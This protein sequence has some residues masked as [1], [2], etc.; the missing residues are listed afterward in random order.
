[1]LIPSSACHKTCTNEQ[2][3]SEEETEVRRAMDESLN[4]LKAI[5]SE[6]A[7]LQ[8][9]L[10]VL[11]HS[12]K[13]AEGFIK[14]HQN[15]V[16]PVRRLLPEILQEI[17][18]Q[19]LPVAH[20]PVLSLEETPLLLGRVCSQWRQIAYSTPALWS[21]LHVV[22][23]P[24]TFPRAKVRLEAFSAWLA[25]SGTLPL[26]ISLS[27]A[28]ESRELQYHFPPYFDLIASTLDDGRIFISN[29]NPG[30]R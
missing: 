15:L 30:I 12:K 28:I 19:S 9:R 21:S 17:F 6:T 10:I 4:R 13:D 7:R 3:T 24:L 20:N 23:A 26:S 16:S 11:R 25:R 2:L 5:E 27:N 8:D 22:A 14:S 1:M 18:C 29:L